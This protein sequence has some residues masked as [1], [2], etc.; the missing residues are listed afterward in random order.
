MLDKIIDL[1]ILSI[2]FI[3]VP[4]FLCFCTGYKQDT[5]LICAISLVFPEHFGLETILFVGLEHISIYTLCLW[6]SIRCVEA[7][8]TDKKHV[9]ILRRWRGGNTYTNTKITHT[10]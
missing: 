3:V 9:S 5:I 4:F 6:I 1:F 8:V 10:Q 7:L 2:F